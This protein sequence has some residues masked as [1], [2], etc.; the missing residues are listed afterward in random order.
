MIRASPNFS[1]WSFEYFGSFGNF[2]RIFEVS[3]V[4]PLFPSVIIDV[5]GLIFIHSIQNLG[6]KEFSYGIWFI[7]K[8]I[9]E[10]SSVLIW[11]VWLI[12]SGSHVE[13]LSKTSKVI[14]LFLG[15][16]LWSVHKSFQ[17]SPW[18]EG[19]CLILVISLWLGHRSGCLLVWFVLFDY[20]MNIWDCFP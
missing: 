6:F 9:K 18:S 2:L 12:W 7:R 8:A 20:S 11:S 15:S 3:K 16:F 17:V 5:F 13:I 19:F 10:P 1:I 14:W 4:G